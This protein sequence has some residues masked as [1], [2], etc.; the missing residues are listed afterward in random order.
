M[1]DF[2]DILIDTLSIH[3]VSDLLQKHGGDNQK[4]SD[5][6]NGTIIHYFL[7]SMSDGAKNI[8][9]NFQDVLESSISG[10]K[11]NNLLKNT[12]LKINSE[13]NNLSFNS[14]NKALTFITKDIYSDC[15]KNKGIEETKFN[16]LEDF[17]EYGINNELVFNIKHKLIENYDCNVDDIFI[18]NALTQKEF[19]NCV[20]KN[21]LSEITVYDFGT[22]IIVN[23]NLKNTK[24]KF[25]ENSIDEVV[26]FVNEEMKKSNLTLNSSDKKEVF[27]KLE[28]KNNIV[29][30]IVNEILNKSF[31]NNKETKKLEENNLKYKDFFDT[32][33]VKEQRDLKN[34]I[35]EKL[36]N[37][38]NGRINVDMDIRETKS[39]PLHMRDN[40][41]KQVFE[42]TT[43]KLRK[44]LLNKVPLTNQFFV[45]LKD[46]LK[47]YNSISIIPKV[48]LIAQAINQGLN[49]QIVAKGFIEKLNLDKEKTNL[50]KNQIDY[51]NNINEQY[52]WQEQDIFLSEKSRSIM[53]D[54]VFNNSY[55][56][57]SSEEKEI[58][59]EMLNQIWSQMD[60]EEKFESI[61]YVSDI[62]A[63]KSQ[64]CS[65][66]KELLEK[67]FPLEAF[68]KIS[69]NVNLY[70]DLIKLKPKNLNKVKNDKSH[71]D[72]E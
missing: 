69:M 9:N 24:Q 13:Y 8:Y 15:F 4:V 50:F 46:S 12:V 18:K 64:D 60:E 65:L 26:N 47:E 19:F 14:K 40:I 57:L 56:K 20:N 38:Y 2:K 61:K 67:G 34:Q 21:N 41:V 11:E 28:M 59:C 36:A 63:L 70:S 27:K 49:G 43:E 35:S 22:E 5:L 29:N 6:D 68:D 30:D 31:L 71:L 33:E 25:S 58:K 16:V 44:N 17:L 52:R 51:I 39:L 72:I 7:Q 42:N 1:K 23:N 37:E 10:K 55:E 62:V 45:N 32:I 3:E 54:L 48:G 53:Y 66:N